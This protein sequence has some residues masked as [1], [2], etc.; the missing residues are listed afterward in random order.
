LDLFCLLSFSK[1]HFSLVCDMRIIR[2]LLFWSNI[3]LYVLFTTSNKKVEDFFTFVSKILFLLYFL[4]RSERELERPIPM[5]EEFLLSNFQLKRYRVLFWEY[6]LFI[7]H[8][9]SKKKVNCLETLFNF[10]SL[11]LWLNAYF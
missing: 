1:T 10:V 9:N 5:K 7:V 8:F 6:L 4:L 2:T 3:L 11:F